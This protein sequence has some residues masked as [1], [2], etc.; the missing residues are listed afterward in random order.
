MCR[1][2]NLM[3]LIPR[4][5]SRICLALAEVL[6]ILMDSDNTWPGQTAEVSFHVF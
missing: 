3:L 2:W 5:I 6:S 1:Y 4:F